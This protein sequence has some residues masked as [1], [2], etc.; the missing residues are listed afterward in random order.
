MYVL[1][2]YRLET[3]SVDVEA[4]VGISPGDD[5]RVDGTVDEGLVGEDT[6]PE[7][8]LRRRILL[9]WGRLRGCHCPTGWRFVR[10]GARWCFPHTPFL[11]GWKCIGGTVV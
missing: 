5:L 4:G 9:L 11:W 3:H 2:R 10:S 1:H 6:S 8:L 7:L